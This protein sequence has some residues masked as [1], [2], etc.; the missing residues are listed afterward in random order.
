[1]RFNRVLLSAFVAGL[2]LVTFAESASAQFGRGGRGGGGGRGD[3]DATVLLPSQIDARLATLDTTNPFT[4]DTDPADRVAYEE[5]DMTNYDAFFRDAAS[6]QG[7]VVLANNLVET[8]T[9]GLDSGMLQQALSGETLSALYGGA[10]ETTDAQRRSALL[11]LIGGDILGTAS[12]LG[13]EQLNATRDSFF[14]ANPEIA[15]LRTQIE[16][17]VPILTDLPN[18]AQALVATGQALVSSAPNDFLGPNALK[19]PRILRGLEGSLGDLGN[20][21]GASATA[22]A[23][24][25]TLFTN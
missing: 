20:A 7:T 22:V 5:V 14:A 10:T 19:L 4:G 23:G 13:T 3:D 12:G 16:V 11:G 25:T 2:S 8:L 15:A 17:L 9:T 6:V 1:M 24:L 21:A 18:R